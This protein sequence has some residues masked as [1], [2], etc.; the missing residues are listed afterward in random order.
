MR[1]IIFFISILITIGCSDT[2]NDSD[3]S[4]VSDEVIIIENISSHSII[5]PG[6]PG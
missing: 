1:K 3:I 6:A 5:Q 2:E 4:S